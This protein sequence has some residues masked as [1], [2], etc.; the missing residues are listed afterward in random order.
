MIKSID[1][2]IQRDTQVVTCTKLFQV[3]GINYKIV[4][5]LHEIENLSCVVN[6]FCWG[7]NE[8]WNHIFSYGWNEMKTSLSLGTKAI[9]DLSEEN[10]REDIHR[11]EQVVE[12]MTEERIKQK[13]S[14][15]YGIKR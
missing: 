15:Y 2:S 11:M 7:H 6:L 3:T 1:T 9:A 10:F 4:I 5:T 12:K 14:S 8:S 13:Q